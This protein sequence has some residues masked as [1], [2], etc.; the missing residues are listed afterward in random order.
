MRG[1]TRSDDSKVY[2]RLDYAEYAI[3]E[4]SSV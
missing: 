4:E 2:R 1:T 3:A